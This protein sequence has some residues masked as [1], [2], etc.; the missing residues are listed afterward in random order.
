MPGAVRGS[1][2]AQLPLFHPRTVH[3]VSKHRARLSSASRYISIAIKATS[4]IERWS[5]FAALS[6]RA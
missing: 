6:K 4:A 5:A 1:I 3:R 2:D